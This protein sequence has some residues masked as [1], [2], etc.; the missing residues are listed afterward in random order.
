M[1]TLWRLCDTR[2]AAGA[3]DGEGAA[4]YPGRWNS[5]GRKAVYCAATRSLAALEILS[6]V[7]DRALLAKAHF[8]A[9]PIDVSEDQIQVLK[10][11]PEGWDRIPPGGITRS[12]GDQFLESAKHPVLRIPSAVVRGEFNYLL[13]PRHPAF[14]GLRVG[15]A[16][17]FAFDPRLAHTCSENKPSA[18]GRSAKKKPAD[19]KLRTPKSSPLCARTQRGPSAPKSPS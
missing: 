14:S 8:T 11:L 15:K 13:N 17:P 10:R 12:I 5:E 1:P 18:P 9:L 4:R 16:E 6:H 19:K 7:E 3:F 2:W